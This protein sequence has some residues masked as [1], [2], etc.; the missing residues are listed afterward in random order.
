MTAG[1]TGRI[2]KALTPTAR[3]IL[4]ERE[5]AAQIDDELPVICQIDF[6][7]VLM[8]RERKIIADEPARR[9]LKAI[10]RL[11]REQFSGIRSR[12]SIRGLFLMYENYLIETEGAEVG[13][14]LQTGRSRNDLGSTALRL[15]LRKPYLLLMRSM[16][17]LQA[18]LMERARMF[19]DVVMPAYTHSQAA[20]PVTYG[21][22]L[23]GVA[24]ALGRDIEG[25]I[26]AAEEIDTSPLGA[27]AVAG[28]SVPIDTAMTAKLLGFVRLSS[29]SMDAVA[30]R[31]FVLRLLAA[32]AIGGV[33]LSRIATDLLQWLTAEFQFLSLPDELVGSSSAM[34]QKRNPFLLEHV[35]GRTA[36]ALGGFSTALAASRNVPFTNS[37]SVGTESVRPIWNTVRD[38]TDAATLLRI[39]I[40]HAQPLPERMLRRALE[41][42]TN[43]TALATD[44][45][46]KQGM[47]FRSAHHV[48]GSAIT[49]AIANG[50]ASVQEIL[51][52]NPELLQVSW[53][54]IEPQACVARNRYG[55][56]PAPEVLQAAG[57]KLREKWLDHYRRVRRQAN[58][59][60][61][62][63]QMLEEAVANICDE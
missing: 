44:L 55:G 18:V 28:T 12:S 59:W 11:V 6:A 45:V 62:A 7:H 24:G 5:S 58:H 10:R 63:G 27:G 56:G 50:Q 31:D 14:L 21:H 60:K 20:E 43:A 29:N 17:R 16:L 8:L 47:D 42:F 15:R 25:L 3:R 23:T 9:L 49:E 22:Y 33:T 57:E 4:F 54:E 39:T 53:K 19:A 61:A 46:L 48:V 1:N 37:I 36:S 34:P 2:T 13:G 32:M 41:G 38:I 51:K 26:L 52:N 30:S 35:Q 40:A